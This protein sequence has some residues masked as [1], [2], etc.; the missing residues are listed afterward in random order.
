MPV[1]PTVINVLLAA[2]EKDPE[3]TALRL[4]LISLLFDSAQMSEALLHCATLLMLQPDHI[5]ALNY[6]ARAAEAVGDSK[7]AEGYRRLLMAL[8]SENPDP[9]Q[10]LTQ[11]DRDELDEAVWPTN[12]TVKE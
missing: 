11:V 9:A 1:D 6:A 8:S 4:H 12:L 5:E 2:V 10:S 7:R 3:N